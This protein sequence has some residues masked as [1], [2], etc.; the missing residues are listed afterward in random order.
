MAKFNG[1][2]KILLY[3][4]LLF[5]FLPCPGDGQPPITIGNCPTELTT[6]PPLTARYLFI[7]TTDGFRWQ[8]IFAGADSA[9]LFDPASVVLDTA[10]TAGHFWAA[11]SEAR[12][13]ALLPFLWSTFAHEGQLFGNRRY[14]NNMDIA[15]R[16]A[17]SYPGY[18]EMFTGRPDNWR[19]FSNQKIRNP[20]K[21]VLEFFQQQPQLRDKVAAFTSWEAFPYI[22]NARRAGILVSSGRKNRHSDVRLPPGKL[23]DPF[24]WAAGMQYLRK[25]RPQVLYIALNATDLLGHAGNYPAYLEAAHQF[26]KYL[27]ELWAFIE[28]DSM[29]SGRSTLLITTDHGRGGETVQRWMEHN[30]HLPGSEQVW[31]GIMGPDISPLGELRMPMQ[32]WQQQLAQT[33]AQL[34]GL[35][36]RRSRKVAP[37][38]I[39]DGH[40]SKAERL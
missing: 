18:N 16:W 38:I 32:L 14:D 36:F 34:M 13:M 21:N 33:A 25:Q 6:R 4:L 7:V 28:Q 23:D 27:S 39:F 40:S 3:T 22:L 30:R 9:L 1:A 35:E 31:L 5:L 12:R 8:E 37:A 20:N 26:D 24:T 2:Y 19:I 29:Y 10:G 15:N 17:F 11:T